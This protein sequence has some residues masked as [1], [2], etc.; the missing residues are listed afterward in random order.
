MVSIPV[1]VKEIG[2]QQNE[3]TYSLVFF[4]RKIQEN[5][6]IVMKYLDIIMLFFWF[7][8]FFA[9]RNYLIKSYHDH[10]REMQLFFSSYYCIK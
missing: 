2:C 1:I 3:Y 10:N 7:F 5:F 8:K 9:R 6:I 4:L